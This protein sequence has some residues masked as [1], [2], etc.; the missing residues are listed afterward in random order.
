M[1]KFLIFLLAVIMVCTL[2]S[3]KKAQPAAQGTQ[4]IATEPATEAP[5]STKNPFEGESEIDFSDVVTTGSTESEPTE[6]TEI[7]TEPV[8]TE[9]TPMETDVP[10]ETQTP[11][12]AAPSFGPDG[13][14]NQIVRP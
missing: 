11:T 9:P 13:Y 10:E 14:N 2:I 8:V 1:K 7:T 4:P 5:V 6:T 3:C 12:T